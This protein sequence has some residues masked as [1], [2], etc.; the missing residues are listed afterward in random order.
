[1]V[2]GYRKCLRTRR[3]SEAAPRSGRSF[4]SPIVLQLVLHATEKIFPMAETG[5]PKH[6]KKRSPNTSQTK[7]YRA[8]E[9]LGA[10]GLE[11]IMDSWKLLF[12]VTHILRVASCVA[13]L[14]LDMFHS[15]KSSENNWFTVASIFFLFESNVC[16]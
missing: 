7:A 13:E 11:P 16:L 4:F 12:T 5:L 15:L 3:K 9:A 6:G 1:M 14:F 2:L 10:M 8:F